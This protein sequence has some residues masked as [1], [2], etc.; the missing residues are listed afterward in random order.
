MAGARS[1][2]QA[3]GSLAAVHTRTTQ[4]PRVDQRASHTM[5]RA[6]NVSYHTVVSPLSTLGG[7]G[8][9]VLRLIRETERR[10]WPGP[11]RGHRGP[12]FIG[13]ACPVSILF[14]LSS[15][16]ICGPGDASYQELLLD[17]SP[18]SRILHVVSVFPCKR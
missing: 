8:G 3:P 9:R 1:R 2:A 5:L 12:L 13:R 7:Q 14:P 10:T 15:A 18:A 6:A 4:R 11:V 17:F 16:N